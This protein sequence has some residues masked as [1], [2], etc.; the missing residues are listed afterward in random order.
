MKNFPGHAHVSP[1]PKPAARKAA[2]QTQRGLPALLL[3]IAGSVLGAVSFNLFLRPQGIAS[4][5]IVGAS[6]LLEKSLHF[7]PA[8]TQ[9]SVNAVIL[10]FCGRMLGRGF[11]VKSALASL[12]IPLFVWLTRDF[13]SPTQNILLAT[14]CGSAGVGAGLG[15]VLRAGASV[16]GFSALALTAHRK[17]G[18]SVDHIL[19]CL[20]ATVVAAAFFL[21]AADQV[22]CALVG[23]F[24]TGRVARSVM[25]GLNRSRVAMIVSSHAAAIRTAVLHDIPLGLTSLEARGGYTGDP[26]E[27][28]MVVMNPAESVRLKALVR[29][30]D[31]H[32]FLILS[33][34]TEV[35]GHG[36]APHG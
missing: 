6:L 4:G 19:I 18:A 34:A 10:F 24:L 28:L 16:G 22:L 5:G 12:L 2:L 32:A 3:V 30:I 11:V 25:T 8:F 7:E 33:D 14:V 1:K 27:L 21:F 20:D 35:L 29:E 13:T 26:R 17:F 23:A 36:F 9:W 31:P 15:L